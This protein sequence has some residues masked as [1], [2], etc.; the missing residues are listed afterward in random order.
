MT[1]TQMRG[2]CEHNSAKHIGEQIVILVS[3]TTKV[4]RRVGNYSKCLI[5]YG[6]TG[7][8]LLIIVTA[9]F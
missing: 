4:M 6:S 1:E 8:M 5:K 7:E 2:L 3:V 9:V